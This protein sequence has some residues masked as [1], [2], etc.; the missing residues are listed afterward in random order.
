VTDAL[1]RLVDVLARLQPSIDISLTASDE[2]TSTVLAMDTDVDHLRHLFSPVSIDT[3]L[4][5]TTSSRPSRPTQS[6]I[7]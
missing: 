3:S 6:R 5:K 2:T 7:L 1:G 4:G